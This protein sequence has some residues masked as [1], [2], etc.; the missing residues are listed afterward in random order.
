MKNHVAAYRTMF[1]LKQA[2]LAEMIGVMPT[3]LSFKENSKRDWT[4]SEMGEI[5]EIFKKYK[6]DIKFEDIFFT[7]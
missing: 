4:S 5:Y 6:P 3:T 1:R 2:E 7:Q